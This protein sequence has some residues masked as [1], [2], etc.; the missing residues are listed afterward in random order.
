MANGYCLLLS[1]HELDAERWPAISGGFQTNTLGRIS[2]IG[3]RSY[4]RVTA[5]AAEH[6]RWEAVSDVVD[7]LDE[8]LSLWDADMRFLLCN[9][10]YLRDLA[11]HRSTPFP[12]DMCGEDAIS[13]A[14]H[15]GNFKIPEGVSK[16]D[17]IAIGSVAKFRLE[18]ENVL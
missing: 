8:G 16:Q 17:V 11:P 15:A 10:Q 4:G 3:E 1:G 12:K 5:E 13:E 7:T 2:G 14:Y 6:A 9:D 18:E